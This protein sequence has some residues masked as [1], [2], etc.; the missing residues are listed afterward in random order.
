MKKENR[1]TPRRIIP[2]TEDKEG[3]KE[4]RRAYFRQWYNSCR[5]IYN[6]ERRKKRKENRRKVKNN[7]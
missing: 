3:A 5:D 7:G 6:K 1:I 2:V 4:I